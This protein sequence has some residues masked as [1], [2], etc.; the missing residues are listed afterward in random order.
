M[1][2]NPDGQP[3]I[4]SLLQAEA[5]AQASPTPKNLAALAELRTQR[6]TYYGNDYQIGFRISGFLASHS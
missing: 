4:E 1:Y 6:T 5:V 3:T 2:Q